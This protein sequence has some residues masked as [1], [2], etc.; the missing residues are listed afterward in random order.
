MSFWKISY[1]NFSIRAGKLTIL[2]LKSGAMMFSLG[3]RLFFFKNAPQWLEN[4]KIYQSLLSYL[5]V[6]RNFDNL[7]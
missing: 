2:E 6:G 4:S 3:V 5:Q 7:G 1:S